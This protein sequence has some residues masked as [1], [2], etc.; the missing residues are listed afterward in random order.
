MP[1]AQQ[2]WN[3]LVGDQLAATLYSREHAETSASRIPAAAREPGEQ[4]AAHDIWKGG[5][6]SNRSGSQMFPAE[7]HSIAGSDL[8]VEAILQMTGDELCR[9]PVSNTGGFQRFL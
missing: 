2:F 1:P 6:P 7:S 4:D 8:N 5:G 9:Q 3:L